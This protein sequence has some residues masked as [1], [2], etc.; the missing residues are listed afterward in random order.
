MQA[1]LL[2][3][4][5]L[6]ALLPLLAPA[7]LFSLPATVGSINAAKAKYT[8]NDTGASPLALDAPL[9]VSFIPDCR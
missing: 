7:Q 9:L 3:P 5:L 6:L 8:V 4:L 2:F 1:S